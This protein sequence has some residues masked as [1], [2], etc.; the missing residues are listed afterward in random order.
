MKNERRKISSNEAQNEACHAVFRAI[1][2]KAVQS[3]F[4]VSRG[5]RQVVSRITMYR[6]KEP[7]TISSSL[8]ARHESALMS[9]R[10]DHYWAKIHLLPVASRAIRSS[11]SA[12][13]ALS[14]ALYKQTWASSLKSARWRH[15]KLNKTDP[16]WTLLAIILEVPITTGY[17][18]ACTKPAKSTSL[19]LWKVFFY[20]FCVLKM[21]LF[22]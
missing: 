1:V 13:S 12:N 22:V 4:Y 17:R 3:H 16:S 19:P 18:E 15:F 11:Q 10:S 5:Q 7:R 9:W 8:I 2:M 21:S 14:D 6:T 20:W